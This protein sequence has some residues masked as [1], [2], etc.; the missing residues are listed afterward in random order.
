MRFSYAEC[1]LR[2]EGPTI[3][4]DMAEL[5]Q[6]NVSS[7]VFAFGVAIL[8]TGMIANDM[9]GETSSEAAYVSI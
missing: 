7:N 5:N 8:G 9:G 1:Y 2:E 6:A 4:T 3:H